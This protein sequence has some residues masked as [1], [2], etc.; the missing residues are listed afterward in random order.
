MT[1]TASFVQFVSRHQVKIVALAL[2]GVAYGFTR[3]PTLDPVERQAL[4]ERFAFERATLPSLLESE[5]SEGA[6]VRS[7]RP[8][9][10]SLDRLSAW[11]SAV[12][13]AVALADLDGDGLP[14]DVCHVETRTD[15]VVVSAAPGTGER[16]APFVLDPSPLPYDERSTA[17]MGCIPG[18]LDENGTTD[19][20]VYYWG[21][22]PIAFLDTAGPMG[23]ETLSA[24]RYRARE[25]A[26]PELRGQRWYTNAATRADFDGDGHV[27]LVFGNYF[28]DD[29]WI[30]GRD[31]PASHHRSEQMQHS[32]SRSFNAGK[33]RIF[34]WAGAGTA[35]DGPDVTYR[36]VPVMDDE[37]AHAWTLAVGAADLDGDLLPEIYFSNDFGPD[38]LLHNRSR[39]GRLAFAE[40]EGSRQL[41]TVRSKILGHDSFK[42]MGIDFADLND[43]GW[44][45]LYVSNIA[46]EWSLEESHFVYLST[47]DPA[48]LARGEAPYRDRGEEL[49]LSRSGWGWESRFG[50]FDNDGIQEAVQATGFVR[51]EVNRWPELHE[52]AMGNDEMLRHPTSWPRLQPGDDLSGYQHNPFFVRSSSGRYF[53]LAGDLGIDGPHVTRAIATADIDGD[54]CLDFAVGN[55]WDDSYVYRNRRADQRPFLGLHLLTR[56]GSASV[57]ETGQ[58]VAVYPGHPDSALRAAL[59]VPVRPAIGAVA[60]VRHP[61]GRLLTAQVDGGNGHSGVRSPDLHF[62]L[63]APPGAEEPALDEVDEIDE[64]GEV[65][66]TLAWRDGSGV[67]RRQTLRLTPGWHTV[68]LGNAGSVSTSTIA[69][70]DRVE[71]E[72]RS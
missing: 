56:T 53:D 34:L 48:A 65:E 42:G 8:V 20:L 23:A 52:L 46:A 9:H 36:D 68:V 41:T 16:F 27:D 70:F 66:V 58:A 1:R 26:P 50:D 31:V 14:N 24:A 28:Q 39:P 49:G 54:G 71:E 7:I 59:G 67:P 11:I 72:P 47:G 21:R 40:A 60:T 55:M 17:P 18:D 44:L 12:G 57:S 61:D 37:V 29:S 32:M 33:N 6:P 2:V 35:H 19:L 51:G 38:R 45:D 62:G 22:T 30:L 69:D 25:V 63:G 13:A 5:A 43:D 64:V 4:V 3:L 15:R 10:P